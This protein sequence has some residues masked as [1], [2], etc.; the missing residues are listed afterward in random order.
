MDCKSCIVNKI[1]MAVYSEYDSVYEIVVEKDL[2]IGCGVCAAV[3]PH[4]NLSIVFNKKGEYIAVKHRD[5]CC[6]KCVLCF[7]VCPFIIDQL[8]EDELANNVF[9]QNT[10]LEHTPETGL[11]LDAFAGYSN[12]NDHRKNGA[13]GGLATCILEQLLIRQHVD[14]VACVSP[15]SKSDRIYEYIVTSEIEKIRECSKSCYYP[16]EISR[17][18]K[19][20]LDNDGTYAI[21]ALPCV[22]KAIRLAMKRM[23]KL[24]RR[25]KYILGLACGQT[26]SKCFSEYVTALGGGDPH[27]LKGFVFRVKQHDKP[28]SN[29][30]MSSI[31]KDSGDEEQKE[32]V[33]WSDG[34]GEVWSNRY[35]TVNACNFCDDVFA[36][37]ADICFLDAWLPAYVNDTKGN[38]IALIRNNTLLA[39]VND[40]I[41][42]GNLSA[43]KLSIKDVIRSQQSVL[44]AKRDEM[45]VRIKEA[46]KNSRVVPHKRTDLHQGKL[47]ILE[48]KL[49]L[50][51]YQLSQETSLNWIESGKDLNC[52]RERCKSVIGR[53]HRVQQFY[54]ITQLAGILKAKIFGK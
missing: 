1:L 7:K 19:H 8:N 38:S 42:S 50:I 28:A 51:K 30:G 37:L 26:K 31:Y 16:V 23:P 4:R 10:C 3:C 5:D 24:S 53:L 33:L 49:A 29:F 39:I 17:V 20:I 45:G 11:Y 27:Q 54:K 44:K 14:S 34:I 9:G 32:T 47:S 15:T 18:L 48:K 22:C 36:E 43:A 52:F 2:C 13:S 21:T 46:V 25:I 41:A 35:F 40:L 12:I 6:K